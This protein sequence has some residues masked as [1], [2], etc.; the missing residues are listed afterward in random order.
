[1]YSTSDGIPFPTSL[2]GE[3]G[4]EYQHE[5][6]TATSSS[7]ECGSG[8]IPYPFLHVF[9][10]L[11][12]K[13]CLNSSNIDKIEPFITLP[14]TMEYYPDLNMGIPHDHG[15]LSRSQW[16]IS[17][18]MEYKPDPHGHSPRP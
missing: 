9:F 13:I 3:W 1:M 15:V 5:W 4:M 12:S 8:F 14:M 6:N 16:L 11:Q 7:H 10:R 18:A 17:M 2:I